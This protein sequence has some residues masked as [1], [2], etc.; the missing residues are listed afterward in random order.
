MAN[1]VSPGVYVIEKDISE[2]APSINSSV[3]GIV[4]FATKGPENKATLITSPTQ[5]INTFGKPDGDIPGQGLEAAIEILEA[6]NSLYYVRGSTTSSVNASANIAVGA[7]P[8]IAI[9]DA[10]FGLTSGITLVVDVKDNNGVSKFVTPKTFNIPSGTLD[11]NISTNNQYLALLKVIGG[12]LDSDYVGVFAGQAATQASGFVVGSYA[13]SG[14]SICVSAYTNSAKTVGLSALC[15][16][17]YT[18]A[19][20][21]SPVSS[22]QAYGASYRSTT[23][24][25]SLYYAAISLYGGAGYNEA[26]DTNGQTIGNSIEITNLGNWKSLLQV[27]Q[28]GAAI[29][30]YK[31][32]LVSAVG[33]VENVINTGTTN[34]VSQVIMGYL[35]SGGQDFSAHKTS[36][37]YNSLTGLGIA[38]QIVGTFGGAS[39][40]TGDMSACR[41]NKF[42]EGTYRMANGVNGY[43]TDDDVNALAL[44]G[45]STANPKTGI[46]ALDDDALNI[47]I[48]I[49]P[50]MNNQ[51]LQNALITLAEETQNF[52]AVVSPPYGSIDTTQEAIEWTNG[53]S[54][55]RTAAINSSYAAVFWPWVKVYNVFDGEDVWYDPVI[56]AARQMCF[57]DS[58]SE[59][60]FAPAG[61]QRG[62]LTKP[63]EVEVVLNQG[64]RDSLYSGGNIVNPIVNFPQRGITIFG[65]RTS[66]RT[67]SALDRI[68]VRRLMI[69]LRKTLLASTQSFVFEPNDPIT[70]E[71]IQT[72]VEPLLDDIRRRRGITDYRV[73]CDETTN[74][75]ERIDRNELWCKILIKPTKTAEILVFEINVTNQSAKLGN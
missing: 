29:E 25:S 54:E 71:N 33:F 38:S 55:T 49:T 20:S 1:Y 37:F 36:S 15:P 43:S 2:Y 16:V 42:I 24:A 70:W 46:Y 40:Y 47:S 4:G 8:A 10:S 32:D 22:I 21:G 60:W 73:V 50:G 6:T 12:S 51:S 53:Q 13:G 59:P 63:I 26:T 45:D 14:A 28:D 17:D 34:A 56:Y 3:V 30:N 67:P 65:Q 19:P 35:V 62:R 61:F 18:G 39:P 68:N 41:F 52:I 23:A 44:V 9:K 58:I 69:A 57:T 64:D 31:V 27:N 75:P 5:L 48:A 66:T 72:V 11:A 7:C 74:T